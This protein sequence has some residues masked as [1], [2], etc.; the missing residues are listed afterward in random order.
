MDDSILEDIPSAYLRLNPMYRLGNCRLMLWGRDQH[1]GSL[2]LQGLL[3]D[4]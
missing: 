1:G 2:R 4:V 3:G